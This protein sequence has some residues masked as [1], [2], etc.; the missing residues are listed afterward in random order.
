M[1]YTQAIDGPSSL[2]PCCW[3]AVVSIHA[4]PPQTL[5]SNSRKSLLSSITVSHEGFL[6]CRFVRPLQI[7][8]KEQ[9]T[10]RGSRNETKINGSSMDERLACESREIPVRK[11]S[12]TCH[13][14]QSTSLPR[15][16]GL[17]HSLGHK[18][19]ASYGIPH[20]ITSV[21]ERGP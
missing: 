5:M 11:S 14:R 10:A 3:Y 12:R 20:G 4:V 2:R 17:S 16:L 1:R 18:L 19:G 15:S 13:K 8:P 6:L 7:P 9:G 21:S